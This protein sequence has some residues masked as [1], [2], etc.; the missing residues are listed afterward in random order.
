[1]S[2]TVFIIAEAGVNH[3]GS[4]NLALKLVEKAAEAGADA[5]KFQTFKADK[6]VSQHAEKAEYQKKLTDRNESQL[7]MIRRLELSVADHQAIISYCQE[8]GIEFLST[9]FDEDSFRLLVHEFGLRKLKF[10]SG[11]LTNLPLLL[12]AA[13]SGCKLILST[14]MATLGEVE[15]ALGAVAFGYTA[16][17]NEQPS[18]PLF[19]NAYSSVAGQEA[20][21]ANVNLLHCTTEYPT[22][23]DD[24]HLNKMTTMKQAF[25]LRTGY[26]DHTLGC[27]VSAAAVALGAT[28]IEKHFTLDKTMEGPDHQASLEP[29]ELVEFVRQVRNVERALGSHVKM[30]AAS[31]IQNMVPARKSIVASQSIQAG[32][33]LDETNLTCKRPGTGLPPSMY[34]VLLGRTAQRSYEIDELIEW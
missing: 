14:G 25:G 11:D 16:S 29:H 23:Y 15:E 18:L 33:I 6:L 31:E 30:P 20:I 7:E 27:E 22:P 5:V 17:R 21:K 2:S 28:V 26:S 4:L 13:R 3:N 24:V 34:W 32:E 12:A 10:S 8:K 9:P 19:H 1:M